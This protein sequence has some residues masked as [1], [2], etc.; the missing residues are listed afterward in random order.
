V[1]L[2]RATASGRIPSGVPVPTTGLLLW[3]TADVGVSQAGGSVSQWLDQSGNG[4]TVLQST[5]ASQPTFVASKSTYGNQPVLQLIGS[6]W[7]KAGPLNNGPASTPLT[8]YVVGESDNTSNVVFVNSDSP[9]MSIGSG[10]SGGQV[11]YAFAGSVLNEAGVSSN[12]PSIVCGSF[13]AG[14]SAIY[15]NNSIIAAGSGT[16]GTSAGFNGK[17]G[18][19]AGFTGSNSVTGFIAAVLIYSGLHTQAVRQRIFEYFGAK[20]SLGWL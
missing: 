15:V 12:S 9:S 14:S 5:P 7:L 3:L 6:Q 19:G 13:N 1:G 20:Y 18:I 4:N 11:F 16:T 10:A 2:G 17:L 8:I